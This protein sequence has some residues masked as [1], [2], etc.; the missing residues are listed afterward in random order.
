[1]TYV[2]PPLPAN[3]PLEPPPNLTEFEYICQNWVNPIGIIIGVGSTPTNADGAVALAMYSV[4]PPGTTIATVGVPTPI[5]MATATNPSTGVYEYTFTGDQAGI[6]GYYRIDWSFTLSGNPQVIHTYLQIGGSSQAYNQLQPA[7]QQMVNDVWAKIADIYDSA[8][9]GP[10]IMVWPNAHFDRGR[11]AQLMIQAVQHLNNMSQP[12][13]TYSA[14]GYSPTGGM[15][16]LYPIN[17]WAG[18]LNTALTMEV[19]K[20]LK[21]SYTEDPDI[22]GAGVRMSRRDYQQRW[23]SILN[24]EKE[25]YNRQ[26]DTYK[27]SVMFNGSPQVLIQGGAFGKYGVPRFVGSIPARPLYFNRWF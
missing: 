23:D 21:R 7:F 17:Q 2:P 1:M 6:P 3:P 27:L 16:P 19:I 10:N 12:A 18:L 5:F 13:Q 25:D 20:H 11:I 4:P 26:L 8:F 9:G 14:T 24:D 15:A 22:S